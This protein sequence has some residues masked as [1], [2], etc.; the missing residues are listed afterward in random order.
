MSEQ[1]GHTLEEAVTAYRQA[2]EAV[3]AAAADEQARREAEIGTDLEPPP[4][5]ADDD[6]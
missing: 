2:Q 1:T 5:P 4:P 6:A 3:S